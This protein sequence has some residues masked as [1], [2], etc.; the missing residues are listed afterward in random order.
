MSTANEVIVDFGTVVP[1]DT[2]GRVL[3]YLER[4][5]REEGIPAEVLKRTAPDD[6]KVR[7]R[8]LD[9]AERNKL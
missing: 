7:L 6:S 2:Q 8:L 9:P 5:L 1:P 3:L 4:W